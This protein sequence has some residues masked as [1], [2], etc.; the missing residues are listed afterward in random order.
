MDGIKNYTHL[1]LEQK[2]QIFEETLEQTRP[3]DGVAPSR[4]ELE[5]LVDNSP[6]LI[7]RVDRNLRHVYVNKAVLEATGLS[8]EQ[9]QGKTNR[10]LGMPEYL[11]NLWDLANRSLW[12]RH[13]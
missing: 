1:D 2:G 13:F 12:F 5:S 6:D 8:R 9:Y 4:S 11:C 7:F 10:E 3:K